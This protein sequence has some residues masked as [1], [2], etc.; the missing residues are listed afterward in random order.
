MSHLFRNNPK[1]FPLISALE[2]ECA[3]F[4]DMSREYSMKS[5][6][7]DREFKRQA[8]Q[9]Q[10]TIRRLDKRDI[11]QTD[12]RTLRKLAAEHKAAVMARDRALQRRDERV[13]YEYPSKPISTKWPVRSSSAKRVLAPA[14]L[15]ELDQYAEVL[16]LPSDAPVIHG[17]GIPGFNTQERMAS[18]RRLVSTPNRNGRKSSRKRIL[19]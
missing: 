6:E 2:H 10:L 4:R 19:V 3:A 7:R 5:E 17:T 14:R 11:R 16:R 8:K 18:A 15:G 1:C 12:V 9:S 13:S